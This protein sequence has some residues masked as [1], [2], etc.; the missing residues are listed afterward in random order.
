MSRERGP[1]SLE[2]VRPHLEKM[3]HPGSEKICLLGVPLKQPLP[4]E[5]GAGSLEGHFLGLWNHSVYS[6]TSGQLKGSALW[7]SR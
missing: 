5:S 2:I 1:K 7:D 4:F 6:G 3:V